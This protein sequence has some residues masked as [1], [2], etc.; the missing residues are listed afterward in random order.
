MTVCGL[1]Y[2]QNFCSHHEHC[3]SK[4]EKTVFFLYSNLIGIHRL[5]IAVESGNQHNQRAFRQ[6]K[7]GN[8]PIYTPERKTWIDENKG[9]AVDFLQQL[10][11]IPS[12]NPWFSDYQEYTT[13]KE[14]QEFLAKSLKEL[15]FDVTL[16]E[17]DS[18]L[19]KE[20]KD[21]PGYYEGRPM[22][23]CS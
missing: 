5:L 13:E 14:V 11:R 17:T 21:Y 2:A 19:L 9:L 15:G 18:G 4:A 1:S 3:V 12:I 8:Q 7:I 20:Y 23:D 22:H 10:I 6:M 16:W